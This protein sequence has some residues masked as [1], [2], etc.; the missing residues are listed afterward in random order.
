MKWGISAHQFMHNYL[1]IGEKFSALQYEGSNGASDIL[2]TE[3]ESELVKVWGINYQLERE[4]WSH[5]CDALRS[6]V[7]RDSLN[8]TQISQLVE[9]Y[10]ITGLDISKLVS[11]SIV[12][13]DKWVSDAAAAR[14]QTAPK[15]DIVT[16]RCLNRQEPFF[17]SLKLSGIKSVAKIK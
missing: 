12:D 4:S 5:K 10:K 6:R 3:L 15:P 17:K 9:K 16:V 2:A 13:F 8:K 7:L 1:R 14:K 11:N